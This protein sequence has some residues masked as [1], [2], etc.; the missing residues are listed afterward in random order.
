MSE[1]QHPQTQSK[2]IPIK[3][4][5]RRTRSGSQSS[6][7]SDDVAPLSPSSNGSTPPNVA[8]QS[9]PSISS[10]RISPSTSPILSYFFAGS[11]S[12]PPVSFGK[13]AIIEDTPDAGFASGLPPRRMSTTGWVPPKM[14]Q[15]GDERSTG[16]LRRLS[17]GAAFGRPAPPTFTGGVQPSIPALSPPPAT[18]PLLKEPIPRTRRSATL[19]VPGESK[20]RAPSPMGERMLKGHF[21]GFV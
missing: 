15:P 21:D 10:A 6:A 11:P 4:V 3:F 19:A 13:S 2:P 7:S 9:S 16:L 12:K 17:L 5:D 18:A 14:A 8:I 1:D 20:P